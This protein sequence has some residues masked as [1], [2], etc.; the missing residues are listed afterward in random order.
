[1]G[2]FFPSLFFISLSLGFEHVELLPTELLPF[3][4]KFGIN[5]GIIIVLT[6]AFFG[7]ILLAALSG[8][9]I[10][11][12][13]GYP[14]Q[15]F[16]L[17]RF[18]IR[19]QRRQWHKLNLRL[20]GLKSEYFKTIEGI[21]P[22]RATAMIPEI[23]QLQDQVNNLFPPDPES[24]LPTRLGNA[25]RAFEYYANQRY[26]ID[27][28]TIWPRLLAVLPKEFL[29]EIE[30]VSNSFNFLVNIVL[31]VQ[32]SGLLL[33]VA[34]AYNTSYWP[35]LGAFT[36]F[37]VSYLLYRAAISR[38]IAWGFMFNTAFDLYRRD[39][40]K[41]FGF[42]PPSN[43]EEEQKLWTKILQLIMYKETKNLDFNGEKL[44]GKN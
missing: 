19:R 27:P 23:T 20:E 10:R 21:N 36:S 26:K 22:S 44:E 6:A 2:H 24:V 43:I 13:E 37:I 34:S 38:A 42:S 28:I 12:Y 35:L 11:L 29:D 14:L 8:S 9:I 31:M 41:Q 33:L 15:R 16:P 39:L 4:G 17:F 40:L 5:W 30:D 18:L 3:L 25:I 7:G 32:I 1:M